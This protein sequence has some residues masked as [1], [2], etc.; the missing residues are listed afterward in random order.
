MDCHDIQGVLF[1]YMSREL[2]PARSALVR[3]HLRKCEKC[4]EAAAEIQETLDLLRR[5]SQTETGIPRRLSEDR[6]RR[7]FWTFTHPVL[8]WIHAHHVLVSIAAALAALAALLV[9]LHGH[10]LWR[11]LDYDVIP[12]EHYLKSR[13]DAAQPGG[14]PG[15]TQ[16]GGQP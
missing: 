5:A 8:D 12:L 13:P 7:M 1:D 6:R 15:T 9:Y 14:E 3:E 10:R 11:I 16:R 4:R 2:G